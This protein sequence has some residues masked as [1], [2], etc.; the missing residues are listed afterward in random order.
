MAD[1]AVAD[2]IAASALTGSELLYADDGVADVKVTPAQV[3]TYVKATGAD[4]TKVDDTNVTL[5]LGGTPTGALLKATSITLGWSGTIAAARLNA[6]VVQA[7][8]NDTNVTGSITAQNLTIGWT[9]T[10]AVARGGT[11]ASSASGTAL[12]SISG[13]ASTGVLA[14]TGAGTYALRT[15]TAPAA[16][17]SVSNGDGVSG[18]P[19]IAL[20]NDLAALEG[21]S[22]TGIARR[23]GSDAWSV[24]TTVSVSEGGTG[25]GS[26]TTY[27]V[28]CGGTTST[29]AFQSI[30]S[31]GTSGQV[32]AS[33]GAGTLPTFQ[34]L[35]AAENR[36][37]NNG[38]SSN[39]L[40][41]TASAADGTYAG[42][43]LWY[44]LSQANP[45]SGAQQTDQE[46]GTPYSARLTQA[47][48]LAQRMGY[49]Q[50][51]ESRSCRDLRGQAVAF[52]ARARISSS[53][54]VRYA[55][56]EWTGTADT[57]T[58]D[59]VND[60]TSSIYTASNFFVASS[61]TVVAVGSVTP[62]ANTW[63]NLTS[64]TGTISSSLNNIGVFIWTEGTV[65]Q[66]VTLDIGR[67]VLNQGATAGT[68]SQPRADKAINDVKRYLR[69]VSG[70]NKFLG[71][72]YGI[73]AT[74][75]EAFIPLDVEMF[76][77]PTLTV[78]A[79]SDFILYPNSVAVTTLAISAFSQLDFLAFDVGIAS[80]VLANDAMGFASKGS[81]SPTFLLNSRL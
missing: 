63:A 69:Y 5:T 72:A 19:T 43:D 23:T 6:N 53:Q 34:S 79:A 40:G 61:V 77:Q 44:V 64:I 15:L 17:V 18:N 73:S 12:D 76:K 48:A 65:A 10:L 8:T 78:S 1:K 16:G 29:G 30:A 56:L 62:A 26:A 24:G 33:N 7:I 13:F 70:I 46:D 57:I 9:G 20:A 55:I 80:G 27:A 71:N 67:A 58:K 32:L 45:I 41:T 42:P 3:A 39:L 4:L 11:G 36:L 81:G 22:G 28:L 51:I 47:N 14:R 74:S 2:L 49:A 60:W 66:N 50:F 52:S 59:V 35:N 75:A 54:P 21:L 25:L 31:V 68:W 38:F 37:L